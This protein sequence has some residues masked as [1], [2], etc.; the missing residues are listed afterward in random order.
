MINPS[1]SLLSHIRVIPAEAGIQWL[2]AHNRDR[3]LLW[4]QGAGIL[5]N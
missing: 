2:W 5:L 1:A 3:F 4:G